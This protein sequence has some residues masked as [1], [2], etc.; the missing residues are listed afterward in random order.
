MSHDPAAL[1]YGAILAVRAAGAL[2][3]LLGAMVINHRIAALAAL[4]DAAGFAAMTLGIAAFFLV[5][6][7]LARRWR[8]AR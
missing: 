7:L 8:S 2:L 6:V 5:P 4:P 1:R 3:T